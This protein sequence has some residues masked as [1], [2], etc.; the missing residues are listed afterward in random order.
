MESRVNLVWAVLGALAVA[1]LL[2]YAFLNGAG[3]REWSSTFQALGFALLLA[4]VTTRRYVK[5]S[6]HWPGIVLVFASVFSLLRAAY[7]FGRNELPLAPVL[8]VAAVIAA[9]GA[10]AILRRQPAA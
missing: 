3:N 1:S 2:T 6:A 8:A 4:A 9:A 7:Y 5:D 10:F